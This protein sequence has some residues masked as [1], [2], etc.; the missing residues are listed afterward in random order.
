MADPEV[1]LDTIAR[2]QLGLNPE[3]L[4]LAARRRRWPRSS[5]SRVGAAVPILPFMFLHGFAA[6]LTALVISG[7]GLFMVGALLSLF[8]A[9]NPLV[10]GLRML[11]V[12][13]AAATVTYL[14]GRL[15]RSVGRGLNWWPLARFRATA[16]EGGGHGRAAPFVIGGRGL[17]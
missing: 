3:E 14:V 2:E 1:A 11:G 16:A 10:S 9:R 12:G 5:A 4:R 17:V 15:D 8:T 13:L 7:A 6:I